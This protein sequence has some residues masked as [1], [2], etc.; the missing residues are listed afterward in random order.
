MCVFNQGML[1]D[2]A[3]LD[4]VTPLHEACLGGHF[5]CAKLLL[6]HGANV[7]VHKLT[8]TFRP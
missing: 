8:T 5:V 3:T 1:V 7:S 4:G 6:D 2:V